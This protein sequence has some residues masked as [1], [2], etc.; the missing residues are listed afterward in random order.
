MNYVEI[1]Q[2]IFLILAFAIGVGGFIR[3]ATKDD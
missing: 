2:M 1:G 3:A